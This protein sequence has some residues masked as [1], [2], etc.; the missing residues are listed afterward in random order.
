MD[1]FSHLEKLLISHTLKLQQDG[2]W[3]SVQ[4]EYSKTAQSTLLFKDFP[5]QETDSTIHTS[6]DVSEMTCGYT[7]E[8]KM[9]VSSCVYFVIDSPG[10]YCMPNESQ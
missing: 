8:D 5:K 1:L 10:K 7:K 6:L 4:T 9:Q 2:I 3:V